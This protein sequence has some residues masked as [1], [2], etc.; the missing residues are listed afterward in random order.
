[1]ITDP[2]SDYLTRVRNA[3]KA[4]HR[5]VEIPASNLKKEITKVL[6]DKGYI[7]NYKFEDG[8]N[9]QGVIKIALKY[10][11]KDKTPAI[12]HLERVSKPGLRKYAKADSLP[13]VLNG[14]GLAI[15]STSKGVISD[16]EARELNVG[17]EIL[18]YVY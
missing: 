8:V 11:P 1:M 18:C 9:Y 12:V 15:L 16:K 10:N 5:I 3:V 7:Q 2:I 6:Y 17:G 14:L 4:R 13:K